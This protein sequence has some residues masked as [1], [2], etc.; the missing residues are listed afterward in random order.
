[1]ISSPSRPI[2]SLRH[3]RALAALVLLTLPLLGAA[4]S[5]ADERLALTPAQ[6]ACNRAQ[7]DA[8]AARMEVTAPDGGLAPG[9]RAC[10]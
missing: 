8:L 2:R 1:M 5:K 9:P 6:V 10:S 7:L 4:P 3:P